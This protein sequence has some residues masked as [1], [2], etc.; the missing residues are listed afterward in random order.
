MGI[1]HTQLLLESDVAHDTYILF[2]A[3]EILKNFLS[4]PSYD[5]NEQ[6][7]FYELI[8]KNWPILNHWK[9]NQIGNL[10]EDIDSQ[11]EDYGLNLSNLLIK[12]GSKYDH[13]K[14]IPLY[15]KIKKKQAKFFMG[16]GNPRKGDFIDAELT[17]ETL[18]EIS[19]YCIVQVRSPYENRKNR[20]RLKYQILLNGELLLEEDISDWKE[21]NHIHIKWVSQKGRDTLTIRTVAVKNCEDWGWGRAAMM[22]VERIVLREE[23]HDTLLEVSAS[24]PYSTIIND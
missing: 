15:S 22:Y 17:L 12:S 19:Y 7:L 6:T 1:W 8:N 20:R 21:S 9:I 13:N 5:I 2:N 10:S 24:S 23:Q 3:R 14:F 4:I 16:I 18:K 11:I